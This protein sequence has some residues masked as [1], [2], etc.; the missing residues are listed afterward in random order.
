MLALVGDV[1]AGY[2]VLLELDRE[3]AISQESARTYKQ[4]LE[5]FTQRFQ[6]GRDSKLGVV[7][8]QANYDSANASIA[9]LNRAIVQQENALSVLLGNH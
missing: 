8:A 6:A 4:T 9:R 7:R 3:L 2:F 1:A 5:L